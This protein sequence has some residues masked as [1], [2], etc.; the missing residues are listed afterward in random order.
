M[1]G[2]SS[3]NEINCSCLGGCGGNISYIFAYKGCHILVYG[4]LW[5]SS[6]DITEDEREKIVDSPLKLIFKMG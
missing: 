3:V 6:T 1:L 5:S 4:C 2:G